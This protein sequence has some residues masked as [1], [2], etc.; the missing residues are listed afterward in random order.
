LYTGNHLKEAIESALK[1][2]N[3]KHRGENQWVVYGPSVE[4]RIGEEII[5][6]VNN[7]DKRK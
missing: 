2:H 6:Q 1:E 4:K 3:E 5:K 7:G